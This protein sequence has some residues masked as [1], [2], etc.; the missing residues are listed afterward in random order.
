MADTITRDLSVQ[1]SPDDARDH[2]AEEVFA[3]AH[4]S[5]VSVPT[6]LDL[7]SKLRPVRDQGSTSTCAA[8]TAA[9][10]KE[11]HELLDTEVAI[12]FSP[13]FIYYYR[14]NAPQLGMYGRDVMDIMH[15]RGASTEAAYPFGSRDEPN[16]AAVTQGA[17]YTIKEYARVNT[18][19]TLKEALVSDGPCYIAFPVYNHGPTMWK[20]NPGDTRQGGH[21]MTVVGWTKKGFIIRNSWGEG[22]QDKGHCIYPFDQFG[23]HWEIWT[24]VDREGSRPPGGSVTPNPGR[25]WHCGICEKLPSMRKSR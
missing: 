2:V 15:K 6:T 14:K 10:I 24:T 9:C 25:I 22:W 1:P 17:G 7:R 11:Y 20:P 23:A 12:D 21:A 4:T 13:Q 18:I 5:A 16:E 3:V 19:P 8:Q